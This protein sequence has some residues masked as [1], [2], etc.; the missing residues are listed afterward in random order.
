MWKALL[1]ILAKVFKREAEK[2]L[3]VVLDEVETRVKKAL[4]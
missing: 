2:A 3:P 4:K 1:R